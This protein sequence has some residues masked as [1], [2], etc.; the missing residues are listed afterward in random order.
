MESTHNEVA[1][2]GSG[3]PHMGREVGKLWLVVSTNHGT[4][5]QEAIA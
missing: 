3:L 4:E 5:C 1:V 2:A